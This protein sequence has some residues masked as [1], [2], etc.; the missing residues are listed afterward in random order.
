VPGPSSEAEFLL[1]GAG[2]GRLKDRW[3]YLGRSRMRCNLPLEGSSAFSLFCKE[4]SFI[5]VIRG[6][7]WLSPIVAPE[8]YDAC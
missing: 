1:R 5:L 6:P 2:A 7:L 4:M 8:P 3:G